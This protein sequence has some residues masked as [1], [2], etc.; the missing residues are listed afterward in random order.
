MAGHS[1]AWT[2]SMKGFLYGDGLVFTIPYGTTPRLASFTN[3]QISE[4]YGNVRKFFV[5]DPHFS[6]VIQIEAEPSSIDVP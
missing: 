1:A 6:Q 2:D 4:L 5:T 3:D